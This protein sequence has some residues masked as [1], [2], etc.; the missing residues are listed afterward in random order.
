MTYA[1][2]CKIMLKKQSNVKTA[3][4]LASGGMDSTVMAYWLA[5]SGVKILPLFI[6]Y[7][8]HSALKER[9]TLNEVL[10]VKYRKLI[11]EVNVNDIYKSCQSRMIIP[12]D[13][14]KDDISDKDLY[15]P[16]RNL[17][18]LSIGAAFAG[19]KD[20]PHLYAAFIESN[21]A[22]GLDCTNKFLK[23]VQKLLINIY[24]INLH[25]PFSLLSK[26]QVAFL[27]WKLGAPVERTFSCLASPKVP[28]GAC[29]NCVDREGALIELEKRLNKQNRRLKIK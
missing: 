3:V 6:N 4:L 16:G 25:T 8:Q 18:I 28:C 20:I 15:V 13:L 29:S 10:P 24:G 12:A 26:T 22:P 9:N 5:G 14:W 1:T 19:V 2:D 21:L 7:G 27:G 23:N 17:L 11:H